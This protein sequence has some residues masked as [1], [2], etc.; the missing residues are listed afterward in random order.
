DGVAPL[1]QSSKRTSAA[2]DSLR[3]LLELVELRWITFKGEKSPKSELA[4][5]AANDIRA[6]KSDAWDAISS[7]EISEGG[8]TTWTVTNESRYR[9][10]LAGPYLPTYVVPPL[11]QR[12]FSFDPRQRLDLTERL[13]QNEISVTSVDHTESDRWMAVLGLGWLF[14]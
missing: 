5:V 14:L 2:M 9:L 11:A 4:S 12:E 10:L 13:A 8:E 3:C 7:E 1:T 6:A